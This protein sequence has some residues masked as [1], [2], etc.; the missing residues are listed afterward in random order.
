MQCIAWAIPAGVPMPPGVYTLAQ[1]REAKL[2]VIESAPVSIRM[3]VEEGWYSKPGSKWQ[4]ELKHLMLQYRAGTFFGNIHAP[5]IIMGMG[6]TVEEERDIIDVQPDGS[7]AIVT[8]A[9]LRGRDGSQAK[10]VPSEQPPAASVIADPETGEVVDAQ[11]DEKPAA[12]QSQPE[13]LQQQHL[14][15]PT[16]ADAIRA[17]QAG[18]YDLAR[19]IARSLG[20][21]WSEHI[22]KV[23][24]QREAAQQIPQQ[25]SGGRRT[26]GASIE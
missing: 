25:T 13:N 14:N 3:A 8:P 18:D 26:R 23:I 11:H 4:T 10:L 2:P 6:R 21:E 5:D 15:A 9:S 7:V 17:A 16:L 22:E 1:A 20:A 19:D 24:A 12:S